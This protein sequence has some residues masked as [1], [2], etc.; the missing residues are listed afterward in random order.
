MYR[1]PDLN[2]Q[3]DVTLVWG[4]FDIGFHGEFFSRRGVAFVDQVIHYEVVDIPGGTLAS[5]LTVVLHLLYFDMLIRKQNKIVLRKVFSER[6][7]FC[8]WY[9]MCSAPGR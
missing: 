1:V 8:H 5:E 2:P 6:F 3:Q 4:L 9:I 7:P